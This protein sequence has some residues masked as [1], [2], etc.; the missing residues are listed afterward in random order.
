M[1]HLPHQHLVGAQL[2]PF[3]QGI[4]V[5]HPFLLAHEL[6]HELNEL[7]LQAVAVGDVFDHR[8][9][10]RERLLEHDQ[11]ELHRFQADSQCG[12]NAKEDWGELP[13]PNF[14]E[15]CRIQR[16]DR[17]VDAFEAGRAQ[18]LRPLRE[19]R[20]IRR[21]RNVWDLPHGA[22]NDL[23]HVQPDERLATGELHGPNPVLPSDAEE[24]LDLLDGH[25]IFVRHP[26][27][28]HRA[29]ALI[30]AINAAEVTSLRHAHTNVCDAATERVYKHGCAWNPG[31]ALNSWWRFRTRG[32]QE[33][34]ETGRT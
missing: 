12:F 15:G 18:A 23:L 32:L 34:V 22:V 8:G 29:E 27:F 26:R 7:E 28:E 25:L 6:G 30:V 24:A 20:T 1:V 33:K 3:F 13:F 5:D 17:D 2:E 4:D 21:H 14:A 10:V 9:D 31:V 11:V 19:H 16:V